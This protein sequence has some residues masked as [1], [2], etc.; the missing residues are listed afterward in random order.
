MTLHAEAGGLDVP[1]KTS[2]SNGSTKSQ[3]PLIIKPSDKQKQNDQVLNLYAPTCNL[4]QFMVTPC[5]CTTYLHNTIT[6]NR[7]PN[8]KLNKGKHQTLQHLHNSSNQQNHRKKCLSE[9]EN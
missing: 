3:M 2:V 5:F 7:S 6:C 8:N 1:V 4:S 9:K